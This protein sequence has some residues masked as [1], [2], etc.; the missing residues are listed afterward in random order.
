MLCHQRQRFRR[1]L[2]CLR[3]FPHKLGKYSFRGELVK[4]K[5]AAAENMSGDTFGD[6][7]LP[8]EIVFRKELPAVKRCKP[9]FSRIRQ[10]KKR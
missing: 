10:H 7:G 5:A 1:K 3:R 8:M 4:E 6:T 2:R 9:R